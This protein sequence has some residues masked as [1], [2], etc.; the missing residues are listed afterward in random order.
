MSVL[1]VLEIMSESKES[2]EDAAEEGIKKASQT[3]SNIKSAN[4]QNQ[5]ATV[6][7]GKI[8]SYRVNLKISFEVD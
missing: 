5:S 6:S 3:V 8:T 4:I 1:K 7:D 2:W